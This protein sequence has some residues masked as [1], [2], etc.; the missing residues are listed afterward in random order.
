MGYGGDSP[1]CLAQ[2]ETDREIACERSR[3]GALVLPLHPRRD[4]VIRG[5]AS[6]RV[7]LPSPLQS[8][9]RDTASLSEHEHTCCSH[10]HTTGASLDTLVLAP[11]AGKVC[12][13]GLRWNLPSFRG[14]VVAHPC[15]RGLPDVVEF[16]QLPG[17]VYREPPPP[18]LLPCTSPASLLALSIPSTIPLCAMRPNCHTGLLLHL[19]HSASLSRI[20]RR[21][22][23]RRRRVI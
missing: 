5:C 6:E 16:L 21:R 18:Q 20:L 8:P 22:R 23:R 15:N 12:A 9:Q 14:G 19:P 4:E 10:P 2:R 13:V 17:I 3:L 1:A 7:P 11:R